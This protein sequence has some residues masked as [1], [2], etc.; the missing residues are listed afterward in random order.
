MQ[1]FLFCPNLITEELHH[2]ESWARTQ[3]TMLTL[4]TRSR[5]R[6]TKF[7][8][9]HE[10]VVVGGDATDLYAMPA[11]NPAAGH[12]AAP[13]AAM[14][15]R[16]VSEAK[17]ERGAEGLQEGGP[18]GAVGEARRGPAGGGGQAAPHPAL[19]GDHLCDGVCILRLCAAQVSCTRVGRTLGNT[20]SELRT[21]PHASQH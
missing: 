1:S 9:E 20:L 16:R 18:E 13:S 17:G 11:G 7:A 19:Q 12:A 14:D 4:R 2:E 3:C 5:K 8:A 21:R 6:C 15:Q 10:K